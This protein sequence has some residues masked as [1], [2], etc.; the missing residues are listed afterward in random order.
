MPGTEPGPFFIFPGEGKEE[1][2]GILEIVHAEQMDMH[3]RTQGLGRLGAWQ[4]LVFSPLDAEK[5][6][7]VI[8]V[9]PVHTAASRKGVE[10]E[11]IQISAEN[12]L[13]FHMHA[14]NERASRR[15]NLHGLVLCS[16][17]DD[18]RFAAG[19]KVHAAVLKARPEHWSE[20]VDTL[21]LL[22]EDVLE[23]ML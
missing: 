12:A 3:A 6:V 4:Y 22:L 2:G 1:R 19:G 9:W 16:S 14:V 17:L 18:G 13:S 21:A 15:M 8:A 20:N 7:S 5:P 23:K 10:L 11:H